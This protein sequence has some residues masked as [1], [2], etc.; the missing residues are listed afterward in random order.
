MS[1]R[2]IT[3]L[4]PEEGVF[5]LVPAGGRGVRMGGGVPKQFRPWGAD[6]L[7]LATLK[8]FFA[9]GMPRILAVALAVPGDRLAEVESWDLGVPI[10][11]T[12]GG[13][14]RQASV[15]AAL[16]L[17]PDLP[18]VPVLIHD[19]VRPFPPAEPIVEGIGALAT[20]DGAVLAEPSTDT[21][22]RVDADGCIVDTLDR[23]TVFRAQTP[24]ISRLGR[25]REA[26]A[27]AV[28]AGVEATDD[29]ALLERLG[30]RVKVVI[31]SSANLKLTTQED[32]ERTAPRN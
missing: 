19:G 13:D 21:L 7:L 9:P 3:P 20:W 17:L 18:E 24:Q 2:P 4:N 10:L 5:L 22:K 30:W 16:S 29:V 14:S 26:M 27:A 12:E 1:A 31:S 8:A 11:A 23:T 25:W 32:W 6:P 28:A 15:A